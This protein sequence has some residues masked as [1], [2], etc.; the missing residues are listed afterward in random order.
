MRRGHQAGFTL[1]EL[2][3]VVAVLGVIAAVA[4]PSYIQLIERKR[5][6]GAANELSADLQYARSQ[7]VSDNDIVTL[8]SLSATAYRISRESQ[9]YKTIILGSGLS[10]TS[11]ASIPFLAL[12]G[13]T[14]A[15]CS[16]ADLSITV[17]NRSGSLRAMVNRLGRVS[18]CAPDGPSIGGYPPC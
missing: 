7:A 4:L 9:T 3:I 13:C 12:R 6:E 17:S 18:L 2:L 15:T 14:N 11:D 8:A 10:V 16:A 1:T 5:L